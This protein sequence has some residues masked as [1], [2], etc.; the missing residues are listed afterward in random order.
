MTRQFAGGMERMIEQIPYNY[1]GCDLNS[2]SIY[3]KLYLNTHSFGPNFFMGLK[4]NVIFIVQTHNIILDNIT[5]KNYGF[6][7]KVKC[8][9]YCTDD[10]CL[11]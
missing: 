2:T 8:D 3:H 10:L 4:W 11:T 9:F 7:F 5:R 1:I 6:R